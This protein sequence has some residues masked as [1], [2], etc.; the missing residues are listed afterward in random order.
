MVAALVEA[1]RPLADVT[2]HVLGDVAALGGQGGL[3]AV[4]RRGRVAMPFTAAAMPRGVWRAG[5]DPVVWVA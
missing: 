4:D 1:G 5:Q 2:G 3:I